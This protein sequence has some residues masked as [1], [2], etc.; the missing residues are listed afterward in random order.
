MHTC[1]HARTHERPASLVAAGPVYARILMLDSPPLEPSLICLRLPGPY[2]LTHSLPSAAPSASPF[3]SPSPS[4]LP[5]ISLLSPSFSH[6]HERSI[7]G[8][9][10]GRH[11]NPQAPGKS[12]GWGGPVKGCSWRK[13]QSQRSG[14]CLWPRGL[15]QTERMVLICTFVC[16]CKAL[17]THTHTFVLVA[18]CLCR[19]ALAAHTRVCTRLHKS[20]AE[21]CLDHKP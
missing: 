12:P 18:V 9:S 11:H 3:R 17:D 5:P 16:T 19:C 14:R 2:S 4:Y 15:L 20:I 10:R 1:T 21:D 8:D 6:V 7:A 13:P